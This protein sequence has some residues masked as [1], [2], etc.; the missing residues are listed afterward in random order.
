MGRPSKPSKR[1]RS[2]RKRRRA[3]NTDGR[4]S[5]KAAHAAPVQAD[6]SGPLKT[7]RAPSPKRTKT[8]LLVQ[9]INELT[10]RPIRVYVRPDDTL[11]TC[12]TLGQMERT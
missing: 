1:R 11:V 6:V 12:E 5:T 4:P 9:G 10:G 8:I 7:G 3:K 2:P